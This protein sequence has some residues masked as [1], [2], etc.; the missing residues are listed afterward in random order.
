[1]RS[2]LARMRAAISV[3]MSHNSLRSWAG[4]KKLL[5]CVV[6]AIDAASFLL[7]DSR[8]HTVNTLYRVSAVAGTQTEPGFINLGEGRGISRHHATIE[9]VADAK[10]FKITCHSKNG[11]VVGNNWHA[12]D[13]EGE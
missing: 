4:T 7:A 3:L 10:Q 11:I 2:F 5:S 1:M 12:V 8:M 13:G 6:P 9:W